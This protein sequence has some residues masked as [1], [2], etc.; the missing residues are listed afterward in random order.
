A[1]R[2]GALASAYPALRL[3]ESLVPG[4]VAVD[5]LKFGRSAAPATVL[6][7]LARLRPAD[8]QQMLGWSLEE[9]FMWVSSPL[10]RLQALLTEL[11]FPASSLGAVVRIYRRRIFRVWRGKMTWRFIGSY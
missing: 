3:C 9:R 1:E 8:A 2:V 5:V 4:T 6:R 11:I 10:R 7:V